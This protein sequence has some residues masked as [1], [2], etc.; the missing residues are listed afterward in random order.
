MSDITVNATAASGV[1]L[2]ASPQAP[3]R[4]LTKL[5]LPRLTIPGS[6]RALKT[7]KMK[8]G[9]KN[10][11]VLDNLVLMKPERR[12]RDNWST[13]DRAWGG[14]PEQA[15][16]LTVSQGRHDCSAISSSGLMILGILQN[17]MQIPLVLLFRSFTLQ[18]DPKA[19][20]GTAW[21][22]HGDGHHGLQWCH[23]PE[24]KRWICYL[25]LVPS[26]FLF[27]F[28]LWGFEPGPYTIT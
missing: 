17:A 1:T 6:H 20:R 3:R 16:A 4:K 27:F 28:V 23:R 24:A 8:D 12:E 18:S 7:G 5:Y 11:H 14:T 19:G 15:R 9:D 13:L 26:H 10:P 25:L 21:G 22:R 2:L